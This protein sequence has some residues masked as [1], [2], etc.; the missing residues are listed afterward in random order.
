MNFLQ[1][2]LQREG[3][4]GAVYLISKAVDSSVEWGGF[5]NKIEEDSANLLIKKVSD[6]VNDHFGGKIFTKVLPKS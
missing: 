6:I 5:R 1:D 2:F 3:V 4:I